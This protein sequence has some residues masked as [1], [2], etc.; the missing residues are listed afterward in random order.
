MSVFS[1]H[2]IP[3]T[4]I[5]DDIP[6]NSVELHNFAKEWNFTITSSSPTIKWVGRKKERNN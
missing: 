1:R 4:V 3:G 5:V 2:K 6:L